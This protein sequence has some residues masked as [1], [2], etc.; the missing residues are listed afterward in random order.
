[1]KIEQPFCFLRKPGRK[2]RDRRERVR[3]NRLREQSEKQEAQPAQ[4]VVHLGALWAGA[5][6]HL[7]LH[8]WTTLRQDRL[9]QSLQRSQK[10]VFKKAIWGPWPTQ[11]SNFVWWDVFPKLMTAQPMGFCFRPGSKWCTARRRCDKS[12]RSWKIPPMTKH[13]PKITRSETW[14]LRTWVI[15]IRCWSWVLSN[16][17]TICHYDRLWPIFKHVFNWH[18]F[19]LHFCGG[20]VVPGGC[21][22]AVAGLWSLHR[23]Q[24]WAAAHRR[25]HGGS[26]ARRCSKVPS[27]P[28]AHVTHTKIGSLEKK[29]MEKPEE[30]CRTEVQIFFGFQMEGGDWQWEPPWVTQVLDTLFLPTVWHLTAPQ[31]KVAD[32]V[33]TAQQRKR[34][35]ARKSGDDSCG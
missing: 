35:Q 17:A 33:L 3:E 16:D 32:Q 21:P 28:V 14:G 19:E 9:K 13:T 12:A 24:E 23:S 1:M 10:P 4:L 20:V 15:L 34:C 5:G 7:A 11:Y 2:E 25:T 8:I 6:T 18:Q 22:W 26:E 27:W 31:S 29:G 30:K